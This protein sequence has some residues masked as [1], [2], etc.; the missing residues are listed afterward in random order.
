MEEGSLGFVAELGGRS[1][2]AEPRGIG[3]RGVFEGDAAVD[4][5]DFPDGGICVKLRVDE[6]R[7]GGVVGVGADVGHGGEFVAFDLNTDG[8][9]L[10]GVGGN[11]ELGCWKE[12]ID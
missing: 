6:E 10:R 12:A 2:D 11:E 4:V 8:D 1:V 3:V 5:D 7:L 9:G